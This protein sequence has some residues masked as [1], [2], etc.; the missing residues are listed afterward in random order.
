MPPTQL[1]RRPNRVRQF[2]ESLY[3]MPE[4]L[5]E[6]AGVSTRTLWSV[7]NG[8][9]CRL[10]TRRSILKALGVAREEAG[11]VFP[12]DAAPRPCASDLDSPGI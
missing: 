5:A 10:A 4:E 1:H 3:L 7:E 6:L 12:A 9:S 11:L 8:Y 2:R